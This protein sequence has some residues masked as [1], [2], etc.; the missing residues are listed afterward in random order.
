MCCTVRQRPGQPNA[1]RSTSRI[2]GGVRLAGIEVSDSAAAELACRLQEHGEQALAL[3]IGHA[4]DHL[5]DH[6]VLTARDREALLR[7]LNECPPR[8]QDLR[9]TLLADDLGRVRSGF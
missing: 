5:H 3:H 4:I 6:V 9:A 1:G 2:L 8:L 7:V